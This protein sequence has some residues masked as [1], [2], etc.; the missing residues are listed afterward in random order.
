MN[1][2]SV[3][4][5]IMHCFRR[6]VYT[7][8]EIAEILNISNFK[9]KRYLKDLEY[10]LKESSI[11]GIHN[12]LSKNIVL[13]DDL[14]KKQSF[15]PEE[16]QMYL[17]LNFLKYDTINLRQISEEINITRRTLT[18]DLNNLK[19]ILGK[20]DLEIKNLTRYGI[21]LDGKEKNKRSFFELY[22]IKIFIEQKY[23]PKAFDTYFFLF[24]SL[25]KKHDIFNIIK[26]IQYLSEM[27]NHTFIVLHLEII[28][29]ISILRKEFIDSSVDFN[30]NESLMIN[31][32]KLL[33]VLNRAKIYNSFEKETIIE[34]CKKRDEKIFFSTNKE[35]VQEAE[36]LVSFLEKQLKCKIQATKEVIKKIVF[37]III[38][39]YKMKFNID[40][41]YIFNNAIG[42]AYLMPYKKISELLKKYFV[43]IDSFDLASL[44]MIFLNTIYLESKKDIKKIDNIT[45]VYNF[46]HR[47]LVKDLCDDVALENMVKNYKIISYFD[48]EEFLLE[49]NPRAII[50]F[51][52][53]DF[54]RFN[55]KSEI[56][57]FNFPI[58]KYDKLKLKPLIGKI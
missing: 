43:K 11:V 24:Q 38:R 26:E 41:F 1:I 29:Y 17:I 56:I 55:I 9:V 13:I 3:H 40:E 27:T 28:S 31:D 7:T 16:R 21:T 46:L 23:L 33:D 10:L 4:F 25:K 44:T 5:K 32:Y 52:D 6:N 53:L 50:T 2:T 37:T 48:L 22:L 58:T 45:V 34:F 36:E 47:S 54:S 18:N 57:E 30:L 8:S 51:E 35:K 20:F 12:K 42:K 19:E 39:E 49:N 15:T 14:K